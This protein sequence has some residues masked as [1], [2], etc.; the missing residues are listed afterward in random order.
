MGQI[1]IYLNIPS[2][3]RTGKGKAKY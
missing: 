1:I 2:S 3:E